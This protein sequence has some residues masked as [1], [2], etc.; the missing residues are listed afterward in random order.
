MSHQLRCKAAERE[1]R[2][3]NQHQ[4]TNQL[5]AMLQV[6]AMA[7]SDNLKIASAPP[8]ATAMGTP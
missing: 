3:M 2:P 1:H 5:F 6:D 8:T 7:Q 4:T